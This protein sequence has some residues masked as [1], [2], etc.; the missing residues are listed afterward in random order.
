M[1]GEII[2]EPLAQLS[3]FGGDDIGGH[4]LGD[5]VIDQ[6][7]SILQNLSSEINLNAQIEDIALD[8]ETKLEQSCARQD[9][10]IANAEIQVNGGFSFIHEILP[11]LS[12]NSQNLAKDD[13]IAENAKVMF[14]ESDKFCPLTSSQVYR[15]MFALADDRMQ[16]HKMSTRV[17]LLVKLIHPLVDFF[18]TKQDI[19]DLQKQLTDT[20]LK[21]NILEVQ[22]INDQ[23]QKLEITR[24]KYAAAKFDQRKEY[25]MFYKFSAKSMGEIK[26]KDLFQLAK[27]SSDEELRL[28]ITRL[29][30]LKRVSCIKTELSEISSQENKALSYENRDI[31]SRNAQ[32]YVFDEEL[33]TEIFDNSFTKAK[34]WGKLTFGYFSQKVEDFG[35]AINRFNIFEFKVDAHLFSL[36]YFNLDHSK[37]LNFSL[38]KTFW[39][40]FCNDFIYCFL[41][42]FIAEFISLVSFLSI[43][44]IL[45]DMK[46]SEISGLWEILQIVMVI[47]MLFCLSVIKNQYQLQGQLIPLKFRKC[48]VDLLYEKMKR[49]KSE[50]AAKSNIQTQIISIIS[51]DM[52]FL[53]RSMGFMIYI[54]IGPIINILALIYVYQQYGSA[55]CIIFIGGFSIQISSQIIVSKISFC[56]RFKESLFNDIRMRSINEVL[57]NLIPIQ[58]NNLQKYFEEKILKHRQ[59]QSKYTFA[60]NLFLSIGNAFFQNTGVF[61]FLLTILTLKSQDI[62]VRQMDLF[63]LF[64]TFGYLAIS[65]NSITFGGF[66]CYGQFKAVVAKIQMLLNIQERID[67]K[68]MGETSLQNTME[69][70]NEHN[71]DQKFLYQISKQH[72]SKIEK[73]SFKKQGSNLI[74]QLQIGQKS[75]ILIMGQ[76]AT[77]KSQIIRQLIGDIQIDNKPEYFLAHPTVV[78]YAPQIGYTIVGSIEQN[79]LFGQPQDQQRLLEVLGICLMS[80]E[81]FQ[82]PKGLDT[83]I[84][85]NA[86]NISGGQMQ[87][88][89]L[90]RALYRDSD[91]Y[92]LDDPLSQVDQSVADQIMNQIFSNQRLQGKC[93]IMASQTNRYQE[94]FNQIINLSE[95]EE[96]Q[97]INNKSLDHSV[98]ISSF[99]SLNQQTPSTAK[100][101]P[102]QRKLR[103]SDK[104]SKIHFK[105]FTSMITY[106]CGQFGLFIFVL[107]SL[108]PNVTFLMLT[109]ELSKIINSD[110]I[111]NKDDFENFTVLAVALLILTITRNFMSNLLL[112]LNS[113]KVHKDILKFIIYG[114]SNYLQKSQNQ[115]IQTNLSKDLAIFDMQIPY[116]LTNVSHGIIKTAIVF[117]AILYTFPSTFVML[118]LSLILYLSFIMIIKVSE[119]LNI[120][121][122]NDNQARGHF[123]NQVNSVSKGLSLIRVM[124][125]F[126]ML[127]QKLV[128]ESDLSAHIG[129]SMAIAM[130]WISLR[131]DICSNVL[132]SLCL[133]LP[134][135][136]KDR[137]Q[138]STILMVIQLTIDLAFVMSNTIKLTIEFVNLS[139]SWQRLL[140]L[141][142]DKNYSKETQKIQMKQE[143]KFR[144]IS[145]ALPGQRK[146]ILRDISFKILKGQRVGIIGRTGSGKSTLALT[147]IG[148]IG[149]N[150][151]QIDL[152][153]QVLKS[154]TIDSAYLGQH[155]FIFRGTIK[156]NLDPMNQKSED[157]IVQALKNTFIWDKVQSLPKQLDEV[158]DFNDE[159]LSPG[160]QQQLSLARI[161]LNSRSELIILDEIY[162]NID[163]QCSQQI[164]KA[165]EQTFANKTV[166]Q[167]SHKIETV[168]DSDQIIV[169]SSGSIIE[170]D[171]PFKLL[172]N[173]EADQTITN[174]NSVFSKLVSNTGDT[175]KAQNLFDR[176]KDAY[177]REKK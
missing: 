70:T 131:I 88:I 54:L 172:A 86:K 39:K 8:F 113:Q 173:D 17:Y 65:I 56:L 153:N 38:I 118:I 7:Q 67:Y 127:K 104:N 21:G 19:K 126:E 135:I 41:L 27:I 81:I 68:Y 40:F 160:Q 166:I 177:L 11:Q 167:I 158:I 26:K 169:M 51:H 50:E 66:M 133:I 28:E 151:G 99:D 150:K 109:Y 93:I 3:R 125:A 32:I 134:L 159:R 148:K 57:K 137:I 115:V 174:C 4:L 9:K 168:I 119:I 85:E 147:M 52:V 78:S 97:V 130:R 98:S 141:A 91:V 94:N 90:A 75:K 108:L 37:Y 111:L 155:P 33:V 138:D 61:V 6:V 142:S 42:A 79:I 46:Y 13:K 72:D 18:Q 143:I 103:Q 89:S 69:I 36:L 116:L 162:S 25:R 163:A 77:G 171:H 140:I 161:V 144:N 48:L 87:R 47:I 117:I 64:A 10:L 80:D 63:S 62:L 1:G 170:N 44:A 136:F 175:S 31:H 20:I 129:F 146:H 83:Q 122:E 120:Y 60:I 121:Q 15:K 92:I 156:Q 123:N 12:K 149:Y 22:K 35:A 139:S 107:F 30:E 154:S 100:F 101:N 5:Q 124:N 112:K 29:L 106:S 45:R 110:S 105:T 74:N 73:K 43:G 165:I 16:Y 114:N 14:L 132:I 76:T 2:H 71:E 49:I 34:I 84:Q 164:Q 95:K 96:Q 23:I 58:T 152:D 157:E 145:V 82:M 53:E 176:T 55:A 24:D 102:I 59:D 128:Q